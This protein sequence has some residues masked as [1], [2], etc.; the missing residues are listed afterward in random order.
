MSNLVQSVS[1]APICFGNIQFTISIN[2]K[3]QPNF[4]ITWQLKINY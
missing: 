2:A 4:D 3:P 1:H